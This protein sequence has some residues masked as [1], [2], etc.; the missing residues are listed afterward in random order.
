[1][2]NFKAN[3]RAAVINYIDNL[4]D[5]AQQDAYNSTVVET[6]S[7]IQRAHEPNPATRLDPGA[8]GNLKR[9]LQAFA[10]NVLQA[11]G[12]LPKGGVVLD[13]DDWRLKLPDTE[14]Q[15]QPEHPRPTV[16]DVLDESGSGKVVH[17]AQL[18][19][20]KKKGLVI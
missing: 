18:P 19:T 17:E 7:Y 6:I 10:V 16:N 13:E 20:P 15:K 2:L 5:K 9:A 3:N 8:V 12:L 1:M 14:P 4:L 11:K